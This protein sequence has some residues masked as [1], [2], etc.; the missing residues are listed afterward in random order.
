MSYP[1]QIL[2]KRHSYIGFYIFAF[3]TPIAISITSSIFNILLVHI[4][5]PHVHLLTPFHS[6]PPLNPKLFPFV[7]TIQFSSSWCIMSNFISVLVNSSTKISGAYAKIFYI[8]ISIIFWC[9]HQPLTVSTTFYII[10]HCRMQ[11]SF[12]SYYSSALIINF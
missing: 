7:S 5:A 3:I 4:R 2:K 9:L 1:P 8:P 6:L 12:F 10:I 11:G